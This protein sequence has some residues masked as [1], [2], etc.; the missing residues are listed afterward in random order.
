MNA[1]GDRSSA[2]IIRTDLIGTGVFAV[3]ALVAAIV[4]NHAARLP[5]V[6][7][8]LLLF[9]AGVFAFLWS[10]W[11]AV[12]RSRTDNI[13]VAQLYLLLS[14]CAPK[15]V[16]RVLNGTLAVQV[17]VGLGTAIARN[18]TDG[19]A[20]STL[21]FGILVPMFGLGLNGLWCARHG[22]FAP[23][24][25]RTADESTT[26]PLSDDEMEQNSHHG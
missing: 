22:T 17:I 25:Q 21:A 10:Y 15:P 9:A 1:P 23:R 4:F 12:Q 14:G 7:V 5:A 18:R 6:F 3:T 20:G 2:I 16:Q 19:R 26:V 13:A 24:A 8:S 11:T